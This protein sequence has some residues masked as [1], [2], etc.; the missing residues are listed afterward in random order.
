MEKEGAAKTYT[1]TRINGEMKI[2]ADWDKPQWQGVEP[3]T[4]DRYTGEK[5]EHFPHTQAKLMYDDENIY[6]IFKVDDQYVRAVEQGYQAA[7]RDC[8]ESQLL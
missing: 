6:V 5:P 7:V 4:L 3:I 2:D 1:V 8:L